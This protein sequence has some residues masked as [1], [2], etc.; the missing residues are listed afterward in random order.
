MEA[1][2][3]GVP[4]V[5]VRAGGLIDIIDDSTTGYL[6]ENEENMDDFSA[7]VALLVNDRAL[8]SQFAQAAVKWAQRWSWETATAK[9]RNIQYTQA[10]ARYRSKHQTSAYSI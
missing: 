2:A 8:R 10:L 9:L 1:L 5:G 7:K 6:A 3:S 4:V